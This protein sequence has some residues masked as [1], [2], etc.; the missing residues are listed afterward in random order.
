M[1]GEEQMKSDVIELTPEEKGSTAPPQET[2]P[3]T[4]EGPR[5]RRKKNYDGSQPL[6]YP[7]HEAIAQFLATP[8][9]FRQFK[10]T[11][12]LAKHFNVSRMTIYRWAQDIDVVKRAEWLS[13]GNMVLGDFIACRE[14]PSIVRAQVAAALAGDTRAAIFCQNRAWF[15]SL[16]LNTPINTPTLETVIEGANNVAPLLEEDETS[17]SEEL[18]TAKE[19]PEIVEHKDSQK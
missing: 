19:N 17:Q 11:A 10:S 14:W 1:N 4:P 18:G 8:K 6:D 7:A 15:P 16:D 9:Q 13:R 3:A 12:V 5:K 2:C